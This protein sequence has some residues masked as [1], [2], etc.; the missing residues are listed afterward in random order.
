MEK[1]ICSKVSICVP[2]YGVE[3]YIQ[4]CARSLF[5]QT[6]KN[7]EYIFVDDCTP[8]CSIELLR[9]IVVDFPDRKD[10]VKIIKHDENKGLAAARNT[11]V[12]NAT[13][14]LLMHVDSDDYIDSDTVELAVKSLETE[15]AD[16]VSF[17]C[18]REYKTKKII[19]LPPNFKDGKDMCLKILRKKNINIG[20]WGRLYR[21]KLYIDNA[22]KTLQGFNMAEDFQVTPRL[23]F[24]ADKVS[25]IK[26]PLYHYDL[27][28]ENALTFTFDPHK[29]DQCWKAVEINESFFKDKDHIFSDMLAMGKI[30]ILSRDILK[31]SLDKKND[32]YL[33]NVL[34]KRQ[35]QIDVS[36]YN[37]VS[38]LFRI[39]LYVKSK[40]LVRL[41]YKMV[42]KI[43][44]FL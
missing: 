7:I 16:I 34:R 30:V 43:K 9:E 23:A 8:D 40:T 10:F 14:E 31:C 17:G 13:G 28:N 29:C 24:Y 3:K 26:K 18:I 37:A 12:A 27:T 19:Q 1:I 4:R 2:V 22:I 33:E 6:Y 39:P 35:S 38:F 36:N 42:L 11:G 25:V 21:R 32:D 5:S 44:K 20:V 41:Y 15:D